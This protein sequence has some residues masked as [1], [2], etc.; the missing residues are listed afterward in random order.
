[1]R[2]SLRRAGFTLVELLV[3]IAIIGVLVALLLPAVQSAREAARRTTC[4]NNLRQIGIAMQ[5]YVDINKTFPTGRLGCDG[6]TS[7]AQDCAP[8]AASRRPGTSAFALILP[9]M[10]Q[11]NLYDQIGFLK[12][13]IEPVTEVTTETQDTAGWRT[14]AVDAAVR[15]RLKPYICPSDTAEKLDKANANYAVGSYAV[16]HGSRGPSETSSQDMKHNNNGVFLYKQTIRLAQISDGT[17]N[18]FLAGEVYDGHLANNLNRWA[19]GVRH[20]DTL[21]STENPLNTKPGQGVTFTNSNGA[22]G[23]RHT[24]GANFVFADAHVQF[25]SDNIPLPIYR[26]LSTRELGETITLP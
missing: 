24:K 18:T 25:I 15:L 16:V 20:Q 3:V 12:G 26:A 22:F 11:Q 10:E 4:N 14:A 7:A 23:S 1:M 17:S 13:A 19:I 2:G 5:N 6:N 9:Q 21:R 8:F